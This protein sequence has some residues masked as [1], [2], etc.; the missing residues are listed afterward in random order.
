MGTSLD[1]IDDVDIELEE[2]KTDLEKPKMYS[3]F[4]VNDDYTPMDFVVSILKDFFGLPEPKAI[5]IMLQVHQQGRGRCGVFT[6]DVAETKVQ[7][8]NIYA[9]MNEHPLMCTMEVATA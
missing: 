8:V 5:A 6:R 2:S 4:L 1:F 9:Q 3:V 7:Q